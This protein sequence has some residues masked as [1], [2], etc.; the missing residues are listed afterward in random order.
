VHWRHNSQKQGERDQNIWAE[1][2]TFDNRG[3]PNKADFGYIN[4]DGVLIYPGEEKLHPE[5]DRGVP[6]PIGTVQLANLRRGL[7][8]HQYLTIARRL[9]LTS[10][11]DAALQ[12]IAP[13]VFSE[14]GASVSFPETGDPY[15]KMRL[16]LARAI[17]AAPARP[18]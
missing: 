5:E 11:V 8:D 3:Q 16:A 10:I 1:P 9:G 6:G 4:G 17:A 7:Q 2:I 13:R 14:A 18:R 15:E 12:A